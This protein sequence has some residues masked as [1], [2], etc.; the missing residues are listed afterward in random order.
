MNVVS[1]MDVNVSVSSLDCDFD[2]NLCTWAQGS[3]DD[4]DWSRKNGTTY[5]QDTGP[6]GDH[7]TGTNELRHEKTYYRG[8]R[9]VPTKAILNSH[10][11]FIVIVAQL[12]YAEIFVNGFAK[13]RFSHDV[14][15]I[16]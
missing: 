9:P 6:N 14:A 8:F 2:A 12:I 11:R 3:A 13:G 1:N 5:T 16:K 4:F 7:P 10:R 15:H